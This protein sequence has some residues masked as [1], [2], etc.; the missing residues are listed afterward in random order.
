M[1]HS[2]NNHCLLSGSELP[3][4]NHR[5]ESDNG[6]GQIEHSKFIQIF[7][8]Q[9]ERETEWYYGGD[10]HHQWAFQDFE[11]QNNQQQVP[12]VIG[13]PTAFDNDIGSMNN[14]AVNDRYNQ[15]ANMKAAKQAGMW[16][17]ILAGL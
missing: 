11:S 2:Q 10:D 7:P 6:E 13:E 1:Y 16:P 8:D 4:D 9:S 5:Q 3:G 17:A 15:E 12:D 14:N